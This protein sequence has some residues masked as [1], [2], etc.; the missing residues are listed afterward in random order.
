MPRHPLAAGFSAVPG[1]EKYN[2]DEESGYEEEIEANTQTTN[3][4]PT[5]CKKPNQ[6][7]GKRTRRGGVHHKVN[8]VS[9][10]CVRN[11]KLF[12]TNGA[13]VK[14]G[15]VQ[16]LKSEVRSTGA[17][18]VTIQ[19]THCTQKGK[20]KMDKEFVTF[21]AIRTKKGGGTMIAIH[22]DLNPKLVEEYSEDFELLVVEIVTEN[23]EIRVISGYGPQENWAEEKRLPFFIALE[24]EV[25]KAELA[26]K[27]II[28]E[29][30]ANAKLG[31]K[32]IAGDP[33]AITPNGVLL[34]GIID[35]HALIVANGSSKCSGTIT[36]R[37]NTR[38]RI[39]RSVIDVVLFSADMNKHFT[40]MHVDEKRLHVLTKIR[41]TKKGIN[42]KESDHN[43]I[44]TEF[45]CK[46]HKEKEKEKENGVFNLKNTECQQKFKLLT[47]NTNMLSSTIDEDGDINKVTK[48]FLKKIDGCIAAC[49]NKIR[50]S[51][52][53]DQHED[54]LYEKR[55]RLKL[56][57]D[58]ESKTEMKRVEKEIAERADQNYQKIKD[59]L[60]KIN[61][62]GEGI[63]AK[64]LW[65]LK[66]KMCPRSQDAPSAMFDRKGNLL[67]SDQALQNRALEVF[68]E[69][70][71]GNQIE[72]H[73]KD[74][75][76]DV[77][78]LCE[79]RVNITKSNKTE[80]WSMEE[81]KDVLKHLENDKCRDPE[82]YANE[83]FKEATA[84]S[85]LLL[86]V[87][88]L[89]NMIKKKQEY[90]KC[91]EKYNVTAL[92]KKKS[93]KDFENYRGV[94][95]VPI[96]RS[97]LDRLTY[98]DSY[99]TIDSNLTDGNVGARKCRSVRDNIFVIG[100]VTNSV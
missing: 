47:S 85:D 74:L 19:E 35:R 8:N 13:G 94:F 14:N 83:L 32:Y 17:N 22:T 78:T 29:M 72:S 70:L 86:G 1:S 7:N 82:G 43:V 73:L 34:A 71:R 31:V 51:K 46:M 49:F 100:A 55:R 90:P 91:L 54:D 65:K 3:K 96:L 62:N 18:I 76:Q 75:E 23:Q 69:R 67:T 9:I 48:R 59:E 81:L 50:I 93:K 57:S 53:K 58:D 68:E 21:E 28:I 97:I 25:E 95:R 87:L 5:N 99:Y 39:E 27:S 80:P 61:P 77:N 40:S 20:I 15:K 45:D 66:R 84:G 98:N 89:M 30:D 38:N 60:E 36:R 24:T 41:K 63:N 26:G 52:K 44:L 16:S 42:I 37:R 4:T 12:S 6:R 79:I 88:K 56:K 10:K 92:H 2:R 64:Q 33:H 11:I